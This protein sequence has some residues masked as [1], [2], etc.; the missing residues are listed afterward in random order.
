MTREERE[1]LWAHDAYMRNLSPKDLN[2]RQPPAEP[3]KPC[4][5]G[6]KLRQNNTDGLC[7]TCRNAKQRQSS[8][9]QRRL[10]LIARLV[11][12]A[13]QPPPSTPPVL[14]KLMTVRDRREYY[15]QLYREWV[16]ELGQDHYKLSKKHGISYGQAV[17]ATNQG[18][19]WT[20]VEENEKEKRKS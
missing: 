15:K 13:P 12:R 9:E 4:E 20:R 19:R 18:A 6:N 7:G 2:K 3:K 14:G 16:T 17:Y 11:A 1:Q 10:R 8:F 5:C